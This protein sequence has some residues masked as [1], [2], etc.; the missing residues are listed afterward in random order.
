METQNCQFEITR[1]EADSI[2]ESLRDM[3]EESV[4]AGNDIPLF[5][6]M[7]SEFVKKYPLFSDEVFS[8][9]QNYC[10]MNQTLLMHRKELLAIQERAEQLCV[11]VNS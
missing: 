1:G 8:I 3:L 10:V 4:D 11:T 7:A 5:I 9:T 2:C 6:R